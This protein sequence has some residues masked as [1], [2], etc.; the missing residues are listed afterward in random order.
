MIIAVLC[1]TLYALA[2]PPIID[3]SLSVY[4]LEKLHQR[5]GH[6]A[7][8]AFDKILKKEFV[9]EYELVNIRLGEG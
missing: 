4:I 5:G 2:V 6:I 9:E 3:R 7:Q 8:S 1:C